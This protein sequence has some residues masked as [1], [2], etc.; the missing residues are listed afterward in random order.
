MKGIVFVVILMIVVFVCE[1]RDTNQTITNGCDMT[2][3]SVASGA[4]KCNM[5]SPTGANCY[6]AT[7]YVSQHQS[8]QMATCA[9]RGRKGGGSCGAQAWSIAGP[10]SCSIQC[11][12]EETPSCSL[13][14]V[15][16]S[17]HQSRIIA[18]CGCSR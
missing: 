10:S 15:P 7:Y 18:S 5:D 13:S 8:G 4:T 12:S 6:C 14:I 9:A 16:V 3:D 2:C 11:N 1:G 17:T